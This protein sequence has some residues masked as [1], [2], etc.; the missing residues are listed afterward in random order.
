VKNFVQLNREI[1]KSGKHNNFLTREK[2]FVQ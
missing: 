2:S 1:Q